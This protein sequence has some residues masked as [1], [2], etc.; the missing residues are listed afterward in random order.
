[1]RLACPGVRSL[2]SSGPCLTSPRS[3]P[4]G[5][6]S[7]LQV[8]FPHICW[9][10]LCRYPKLTPNSCGHKLPRKGDGEEEC[11][12]GAV[13]VLL[14][15]GGLGGRGQGSGLGGEPGCGLDSYP[16]KGRLQ[17]PGSFLGWI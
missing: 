16:F 7:F 15:L 17:L 12:G 1:M 9:H 5:C 13:Q 3:F 4:G 2:C 11:G 8:L 10:V 14:T 6:S